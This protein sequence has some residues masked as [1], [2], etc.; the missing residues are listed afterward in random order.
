MKMQKGESFITPFP[1]PQMLVMMYINFAQGVMLTQDYTIAVFMVRDFLAAADSEGGVAEA[2]EETVSRLSGLLTACYRYYSF[3]QLLT[4]LPMGYMSNNIGRKPVLIIGQLACIIGMLA[5][6]LSPNYTMALLAHIFVGALNA[7]IGAWKCMI[8]E[9]GD[10]LRQGSMFGYM[11]VGWGLGVISGPIVSGL[12]ARP[13]GR[14]P[15]MPLCEPSQL[16]SERPYFFVCFCVSMILLLGLVLSMWILHE[17]LASARMKQHGYDLSVFV[18]PAC[19]SELAD[20]REAKE[21]DSLLP[22]VMSV[23]SSWNGIREEEP[24]QGLHNDLAQSEQSEPAPKS[25]LPASKRASLDKCEMGEKSKG[26]LIHSLHKSTLHLH[27]LVPKAQQSRAVDP[28]VSSGTNMTGPS[29]LSE[30]HGRDSWF[31]ELRQLLLGKRKEYLRVDVEENSSVFTSSQS[32]RWQSPTSMFSEM[33][34]EGEQSRPISSTSYLPE[35]TVEMRGVLESNAMPKKGEPRV[36]IKAAEVRDQD[37]AQLQASDVKSHDG[38]SVHR[39]PW[40]TSRTVL[41]CIFSYGLTALLYAGMDEGFPLFATAPLSSSGL[42]MSET[43]LVAPLSTFG[44]TLMIFSGWGYAPMQRIFG[45]LALTRA[46][47]VGSALACFMY[48]LVSVAQQRSHLVLANVLLYGG[49]VVRALC[50]ACSFNGSIIMVNASPEPSELGQVNG[51]GQATASLVRGLGP[52][53]AGLIWAFSLSMHLDGQQFLMYGCV[54][55]IALFA[56]VA[57]G[58]VTV[59]RL[60]L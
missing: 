43:D 5:F 16:N 42:G 8:G 4:S 34:D 25:E 56:F 54:A 55:S 21:Y 11:T 59:P 38:T 26:N 33:S 3:S 7:I 30:G 1:W 51:L 17:T 22:R 57:W 19:E 36:C 50:Q 23:E 48:P 52:A 44:V 40:Y 60:K 53:L 49:M 46:G 27:P 45:T 47:L 32:A 2:D 29:F 24:S 13:C 10:S 58:Q 35:K 39:Y 31:R 18:Q 37:A 6:G 15:G 41:L 28:H 20:E 9:S 12:A 14:I